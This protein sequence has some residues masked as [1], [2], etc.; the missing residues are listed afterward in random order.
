MRAASKV[1]TAK[2]C[3]DAL[4]PFDF[5]LLT[6]A[7]LFKIGFGLNPYPDPRPSPLDA[8]F[9]IDI[10]S[11]ATCWR[12]KRGRCNLNRN[13]LLS[14]VLSFSLLIPAVVWAQ[15]VQATLRGSLQREQYV[16]IY[17]Q[18]PNSTLTSS[19]F[20]TVNKAN[21]SSSNGNQPC[22]I[23]LSMKFNF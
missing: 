3:P 21:V 11:V 16:N 18:Q 15:G 20:G 22:Y 10:R 23:Q 13:A 4:L 1:R 5:C 19:G 14:S 7:L 17:Q 9:L 6:F 2:P 8:L 12:N